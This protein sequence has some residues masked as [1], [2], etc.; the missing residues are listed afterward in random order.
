VLATN[1]VGSSVLDVRQV[2]GGRNSR[3]YRVDTG[4]GLFA[5]KQY[6]SLADDSRDRLTTETR[7][8][9]WMA[10]HGIDTVPRVVSIDKTMHCVLLSWIEGAGV[11]EVSPC[12]VDQVVNFLSALQ[13]LRRTFDF[14][15]PQLG[16]EACL[17]GAEIEHQIRTR[18]SQLGSLDGEVTLQSFL[19]REFYDLFEHFLAEAR[20]KLSGASL[21]FDDN[22]DQEWQTLAPS[23]FGFHNSIRDR[24]GLLTFLDFEYF[25]WDDPVKLTSDAL[26]HPSTPRSESIRLR[27]QDALMRLYGDDP[28][29]SK[30]LAAFFPLFG[31]RWV[32]ILLNEFHPNCWERRVL[33]GETDDWPH[34]KERQLHAARV[35]LSEISNLKGRK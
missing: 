30:R 14:P 31:L 27:L 20:R 9:Q 24:N 28:S 33:A 21:S 2:G 3:V 22:L 6:P 32:V 34:V 13:R 10:G 19:S 4:H 25:G 7:A 16:S 17:S 1:L 8:L 18:L 12:D 26:L 29:F 11:A 23:D 5:L 15:S 35:M